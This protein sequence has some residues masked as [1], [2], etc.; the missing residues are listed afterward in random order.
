[1]CLLGVL[2]PKGYMLPSN[3]LRLKYTHTVVEPKAHVAV[4]ITAGE[5]GKG[6]GEPRSLAN[7]ENHQ[8]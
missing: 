1:M 4:P 2:T 5:T 3:G 7:T 6:R 8:I